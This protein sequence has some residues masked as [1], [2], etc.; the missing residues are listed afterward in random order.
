MSEPTAEYKVKKMRGIQANTHICTQHDR[1]IN[2]EDC[3]G[4]ALIITRLS[5]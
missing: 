5:A 2:A 1:G 3:T 4:F